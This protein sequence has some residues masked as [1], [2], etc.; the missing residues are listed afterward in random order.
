MFEVFWKLLSEGKKSGLP[1]ELILI[2]VLTIAIGLG[3]YKVIKYMI[4]SKKDITKGLSETS[5]NNKQMAEALTSINL[6]LT[7]VQLLLEKKD[8][9]ISETQAKVLYG[10]IVDDMFCD[11]KE[12]YYSLD[13]WLTSTNKDRMNPLVQEAVAER[14]TLVFDSVFKELS[15]RLKYF[16]YKD[17]YLDTYLNDSF[18]NEFLHVKQH[19]YGTILTQSN[20]ILE[21]VAN[22]KN[23]F[24]NDFNS[25]LRDQQ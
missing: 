9:R 22:K 12:G 13:R 1:L 11:I 15:G 7:K 8:E 16:K 4:A 24:I 17:S 14:N 21:Y 20:G 19:I 10:L 2:V 23:L 6:S 5:K 3:S 25:F 18:N